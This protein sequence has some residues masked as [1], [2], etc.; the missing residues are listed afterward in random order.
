LEGQ[1]QAVENTLNVRKFGVKRQVQ[2][3]AH[4]SAQV[5]Q[6]AG[7]KLLKFSEQSAF[8]GQLL[9]IAGDQPLPHQPQF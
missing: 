9:R 6:D 5:I 4:V 7:G 1:A 8:A 3:A 2:V